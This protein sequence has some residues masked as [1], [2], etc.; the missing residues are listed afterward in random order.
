[1]T[2]RTEILDSI[3]QSAFWQ[4]DPGEGMGSVYLANKYHDM[5][6]GQWSKVSALQVER[7]LT[8]KMGR[9][10]PGLSGEKLSEAVEHARVSLEKTIYVTAE[11]KIRKQSIAMFRK[12]ATD[13]E[14]G[15]G[16][17]QA[18]G[19]MLGEIQNLEPGKER[20]ELLMAMGFDY[21][22]ADGLDTQ[23][24]M[25]SPGEIFQKL[26]ENRLA[27]IRRSPLSLGEVSQNMK[28]TA[29]AMRALA[30]RLEVQRDINVFDLCPQIARGVMSQMS[31]DSIAYQAID[32]RLKDHRM[33]KKLDTVFG[34]AASVL[35]EIGAMALGPVGVFTNLAWNVASGVNGAKNGYKELEL[36]RLSHVAGG[37]S[38]EEFRANRQAAYGDMLTGASSPLTYS[39]PLSSAAMQYANMQNHDDQ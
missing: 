25:N 26:S 32:S 20:I 37:T 12:M 13:L 7:D 39:L 27:M 29:K 5:D 16:S 38:K 6:L 23:M 19:S 33:Y 34:I 28:N 30:K 14:K 31:K 10:F 17:P 18:I 9:A 1:M 24:T 4:Q 36:S 3:G 21:E 11:K 22:A 15:A 2:K 8:D 35:F